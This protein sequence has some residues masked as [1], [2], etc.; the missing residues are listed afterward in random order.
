[1]SSI[2]VYVCLFGERKLIKEERGKE[3]RSTSKAGIITYKPRAKPE[4]LVLIDLR[5]QISIVLGSQ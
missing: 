1:M 2:F 4:M 3:L 5:I